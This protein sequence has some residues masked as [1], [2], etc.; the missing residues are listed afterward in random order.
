MTNYLDKFADAYQ[1]DPYAIDNRL[2]LNWYPERI[3][4]LAQGDSLLELGLG[5][6]Y[7]S[8]KFNK[9]FTRHVVIEGSEEIIT[10][11]NQKVGPNKIEIIRTYFEDYETEEKFDLIVMGFVLEHVEDPSLVL[12]KFKQ[13]L[14]SNGSIFITV[15]NYEALN[16]RLGYEAGLIKNIEE[17]SQ[18][19][20]KQG[21][22]RLFTVES[23]KSLVTSNGFS[24]KTVEGLF[25]K[26]IT[27]Q[28]IIK[29]NLSEEILQAMLKVGVN[30][31]ELCVGILMEIKI[32]SL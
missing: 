6:G 30:Y 23:L 16:K 21:H 4:K 26:P 3:L 8:L 31:P 13:F 19:D 15:P 17:L 9:K 27:T 28:Q 20:L 24:V 5:H 1:N 32:N 10:Q 18:A 11:F 14:N 7:T 12:Q 2:I 29:L 22:R 25:L